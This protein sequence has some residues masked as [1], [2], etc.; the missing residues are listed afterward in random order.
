[1]KC[2]KCRGDGESMPIKLPPRWRRA[3]LAV[4]VGK[5]AVTGA[6]LALAALGA[7]NIATAATAHHWLT[8]FEHEHLN[9]VAWGGG[10]AGGV[11]RIVWSR[12]A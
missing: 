11:A 5:A 2:E 4:T 7:M 8:Q 1:M 12:L 3:L 9:M 10:I 6:G